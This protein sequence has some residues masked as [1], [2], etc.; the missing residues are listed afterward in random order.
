M[1]R[2]LNE[3]TENYKKKNK[4]DVNIQIMMNFQKRAF[5]MRVSEKVPN[6]NFMKG[7]KSERLR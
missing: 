3:S 1:Q 2:R 7:T 5:R 6:G 4:N